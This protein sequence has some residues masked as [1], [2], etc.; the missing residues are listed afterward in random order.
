MPHSTS[1][2]GTDIQDGG[3][4]L[5]RIPL[6][7][8]LVNRPSLGASGST[9]WHHAYRWKAMTLR[10]GRGKGRSIMLGSRLQQRRDIRKLLKWG[11]WVLGACYCVGRRRSRGR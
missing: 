7:R 2:I 11:D 4:G 6:P 3:Y 10:L 1:P 9:T 8:T 5:P